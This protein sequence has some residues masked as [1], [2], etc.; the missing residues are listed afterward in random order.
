MAEAGLTPMQILV[1][2]TANGAT[3]MGRG[4]ELGQIREGMLG[5]V[6]VLDADPLTDIRNTRKIYRVIRGGAIYER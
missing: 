1:S 4:K 5:D 3:L 6:L 2:A